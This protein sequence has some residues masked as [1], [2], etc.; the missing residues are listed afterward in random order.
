M[1]HPCVAGETYLAK[2]GVPFTLKNQGEDKLVLKKLTGDN[3][4][5]VLVVGNQPPIK[6]FLESEWSELLDLAGYPK[7]NPLDNLQKL[8]PTASKS[9]VKDD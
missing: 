6:G 9:T 2:R 3:Q 1:W 5:P 7:S 8:S 4:V